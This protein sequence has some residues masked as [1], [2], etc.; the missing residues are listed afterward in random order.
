MTLITH[1]LHQNT[2][3]YIFCRK[4]YTSSTVSNFLSFQKTT[5]K[6]TSTLWVSSFHIF[7]SIKSCR[8]FM[9]FGTSLKYQGI[10]I[11][12]FWHLL[13]YSYVILFAISIL[14]HHWLHFWCY[15]LCFWIGIYSYSSV[16]CPCT[17]MIFWF[18]ITHL[19]PDV[20]HF[21]Y[22]VFLR[23]S[24]A[25]PFIYSLLYTAIQENPIY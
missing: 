21:Q 22:Q 1:P 2:E 9:T 4:T 19:L 8:P 14:N 17:K 11:N 20:L 24:F 13:P 5:G 12:I 18:G 6:I 23:I 3:I 25:K 15:V 16:I 7:Y 10:C